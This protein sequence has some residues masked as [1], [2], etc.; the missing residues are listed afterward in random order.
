MKSSFIFSIEWRD[1]LDRSRSSGDNLRAVSRC[2]GPRHIC[3]SYLF[4]VLSRK[5]YL[6]PPSTWM[7]KLL[8]CDWFVVDIFADISW[9]LLSSRVL[10]RV[11]YL[12]LIALSR[13]CKLVR[14][15]SMGSSISH[16][17]ATVEG[18]IGVTFVHRRRVSLITTF[19]WSIYH[20]VYYIRDLD[21]DLEVALIVN[22]VSEVC[23]GMIQGFHSSFRLYGI[24]CCQGCFS[25]LH[26]FCQDVPI[27]ERWTMQC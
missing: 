1:V 26:A 8:H 24:A 3:S 12:F 17:F 13:L 16:L 5:V 20:W 6:L 7:I 27:K 25:F 19:R 4:V 2:V 9:R 18:T 23:T 10:F 21:L 11:R 14:D 22:G 15:S